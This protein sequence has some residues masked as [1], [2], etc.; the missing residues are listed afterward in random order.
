VNDLK[1][2]RQKFWWTKKIFG[3]KFENFVEKFVRNFVR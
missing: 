1:K 3:G 2:G